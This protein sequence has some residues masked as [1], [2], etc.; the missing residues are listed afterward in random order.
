VQNEKGPTVL[1]H[2]EPCSTQSGALGLRFG[3]VNQKSHTAA[4][5]VKGLEQGHSTAGSQQVSLANA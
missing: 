4:I 1:E 2:S 5:K 3:G